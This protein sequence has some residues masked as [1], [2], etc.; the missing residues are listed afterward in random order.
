MCSIREDN[1]EQKVYPHTGIMFNRQRST[2][3]W[4]FAGTMSCV[5]V[6]LQ[7]ANPIGFPVGPWLIPV[8]LTC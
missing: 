2:P 6:F 5:T 4:V 1:V 8:N 7:S 3:N